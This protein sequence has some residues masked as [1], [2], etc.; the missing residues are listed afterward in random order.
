MRSLL[1][2][3]LLTLVPLAHAV[4]P[5]SPEGRRI[6]YL[7]TSVETLKDAEFIRNDSTY[8][9]KAAG[10]HL[11]LKLKSAGSRVATAEDFIR[12]CASASSLS[13]KPYRIRFADGHEVTSEE[14]LRAR[15]NDLGP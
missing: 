9:A 13:G 12:L 4:N 2:V 7:I 3:V 14:F 5:D 15:L 6:E 10:D 11:R 8:G 1:A